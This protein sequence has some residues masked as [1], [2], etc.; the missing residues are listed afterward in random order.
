MLTVERL[1]NAAKEYAANDNLKNPLISPMFGA[2]ENLP[3]IL[4]QIGTADLLLWDCRKFYLKCLDAGIE[5]KYEEF[6]DA[7]HDFM[8]ARIF[9]RN[10]KSLEIAGRIFAICRAKN[11][12]IC[13][14]ITNYDRN[15]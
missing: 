7:F 15:P 2:L 8:M 12:P 3:P 5:I 11:L 10:A 4:L 9:A 14:R 13:V 6:P 1:S